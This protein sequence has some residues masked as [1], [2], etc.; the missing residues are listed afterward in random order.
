MPEK[1]QH[2]RGPRMPF[3][4][5]LCDVRLRWESVQR[6]TVDHVPQ[7]VESDEDQSCEDRPQF[8]VFVFADEQGRQSGF[9]KQWRRSAFR[10][11]F[12]RA[13]EGAES[14][15]KHESATR[16]EEVA[17]RESVLVAEGRAIDVVRPT[18]HLE[19]TAGVLT[20]TQRR[21][22]DTFDCVRYS[23]YASQEL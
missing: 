21:V 6:T 18:R 22:R 7:P 4:Q 12:H 15:E 13:A 9:R 14:S 11:E 20:T 17:L 3:K 2:A 19:V 5:R 8:G 23:R 16:G 1:S 10:S